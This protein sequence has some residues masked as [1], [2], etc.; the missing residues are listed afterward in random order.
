MCVSIDGLFVVLL[1]WMY[2]GFGLVVT[3]ACGYI[4]KTETVL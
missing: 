2:P 4:I 3:V 1:L